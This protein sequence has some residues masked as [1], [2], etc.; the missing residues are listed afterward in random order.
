[1]AIGTSRRVRRGA[2]R[3][4]F[5]VTAWC[6][7]P[8]AARAQVSLAWPDAPAQLE[9][10]TNLEECAFAVHRIRDS[11]K[12]NGPVWVDTL[13]WSASEATAPLPAPARQAAERCGARF[14]AAA[15]TAPR[16]DMYGTLH[17][18]LMAHQDSVAAR[19]AAHWL[20]F[21]PAKAMVERAAVLDS[22]LTQY[23]GGSFGDLA[24]AAPAR[25]AAAERLL[26]ELEKLD[27]AV[28]PWRYRLTG[29]ERM[30]AAALA[31]EDTARA[32]RAAERVRA[33]AAT[34][35]SADRRRG[36]ADLAVRADYAALRVLTEQAAADSLRRSTD[37]FIALQR[38]NWAKASGESG[39]ALRFPI[40]ETAP[41]LEG[42]FWFNRAEGSGA[43]PSKGKIA[44]V[45]FLDHPDCRLGRCHEGYAVLRRLS[46]RFAGLE[47]T[48]VSQTYGYVGAMDPPTPEVEAK[49]VSDHWLGERKVPGALVVSATDFWRLPNPDG[50]R[51]NREV[52]NRKN[53]SFGRRWEVN[54]SGQAFVVD[55]DGRIVYVEGLQR[56][57]ERR[58]TYF[59]QALFDQQTASR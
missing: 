12:W 35:T 43:R 37:A 34:L 21:V 25:M 7:L 16:G 26:P 5:A 57:T 3:L 42:R 54:S 36:E 13:P 51:V 17:L 53:Y 8:A 44:L 40:G 50:R 32:R 4:A 45:V 1:M 22:I 59:L 33:V 30:L 31:T 19:V 24:G 48:L 6:L 52:P 27:P 38:D 28:V 39:E 20:G 9:R 55:R 29:P 14:L 46:R 18:A 49:L 11:L 41:P 2:A 10:Y 56:I 47:I 23:L 58:L 15:D